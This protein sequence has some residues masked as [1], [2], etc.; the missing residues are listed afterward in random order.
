MKNRIETR[1]TKILYI[2]T[3]IFKH[4]AKYSIVGLR[5]VGNVG[6]V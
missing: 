6:N 5:N 1:N 2:I 4:P 3:H